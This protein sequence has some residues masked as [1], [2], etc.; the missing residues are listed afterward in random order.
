MVTNL[1]KYVREY[2]LEEIYGNVIERLTELAHMGIV[3]NINGEEKRVFFACAL[4]V[5]MFTVNQKPKP[6]GRHFIA[7]GL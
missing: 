3:L 2:S 1:E 4:F 7:S 6:K 5:G